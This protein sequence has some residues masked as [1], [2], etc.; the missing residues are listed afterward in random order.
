MMNY[1]LTGKIQGRRYS[2]STSDY[3]YAMQKFKAN[4][5]DKI[6]KVD[7]CGKRKLLFK[8]SEKECRK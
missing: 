4:S 7:I 5:L 6:W 1:L 2:Y 3:E 8:F